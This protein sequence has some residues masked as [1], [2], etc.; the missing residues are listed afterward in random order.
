[1]NTVSYSY[2][3]F[4]QVVSVIS[5]SYIYVRNQLKE[6]GIKLYDRKQE[7]KYKTRVWKILYNW[8]SLVYFNCNLLNIN[9]TL[10]E[11]FS[12]FW[13]MLLYNTK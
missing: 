3:L 2:W 9:Y 6:S 8:V 11:T 5:I 1:M 10:H 4:A 12:S 13:S 7:W